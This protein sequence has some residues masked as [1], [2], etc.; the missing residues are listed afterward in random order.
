MYMKLNH[1]GV[2]V[3]SI[4]NQLKVWKGILGMELIE[5]MEVPEQKVLVAILSVGDTHIELLE[6][7]DAKSTV[8]S[9]IEKRGEGL[10]HLCFGVE[11]IEQVLQ[12]M[13][14]EDI[15]LIDEV[16]K[17]GAS[18][19]KIAFVHPESMGGVLIELEEL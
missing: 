15:K 7:L 1:I 16:P 18:G 2:A 12:E 19:K 5:V 3:K 4:E 11:H 17:I 8:H 10:H 13:K 9:F 14:N 6:A